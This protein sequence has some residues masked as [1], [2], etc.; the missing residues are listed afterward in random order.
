M[1]DST[2]S[3]LLCVLQEASVSSYVGRT[4]EEILRTP[5]DLDTHVLQKLAQRK[6]RE[7]IEKVRVVLS[8]GCSCSR[9]LNWYI[10]LQSASLYSKTKVG[11]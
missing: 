3:S 7:Y 8:I 1:D 4:I 9:E 11:V 5:L 10:T 6:L 2:K